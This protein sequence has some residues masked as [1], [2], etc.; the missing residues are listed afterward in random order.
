[1]IQGSQVK[2]EG[3]K[4]VIEL[5]KEHSSDSEAEKYLASENPGRDSPPPSRLEDAGI[6]NLYL[7]RDEAAIKETDNKYGAYCTAIALDLLRINE[8]AQE[9]VN[10]TYMSAWEQIP[11]RIPECL[12]A[13]LGRIT[14]NIAIGRYRKMH[15]K[16]RYNG[17]E[18]ALSELEECLPS[19]GNVERE[20][21][22]KELGG[23]ISDWLDGLEE[24]DR[25]IFVRRYWYGDTAAVL[26]KK[27]GTSGSGMSRKLSR[28][29]ESL[30]EHLTER[31]DEI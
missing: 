26:A 18:V 21:D 13:F 25:M 22:A 24:Q 10:D 29:R 28:M 6:I 16:K 31:G 23:H 30:R 4:K 7:Q 2:S 1:M 5:Q 20:F 15:A 19:A 3:G 11:P 8:D 17:F 14:R 9:C 12:R 27:T